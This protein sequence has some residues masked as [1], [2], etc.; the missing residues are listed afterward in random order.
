MKIKATKNTAYTIETEHGTIENLMVV[1]TWNGFIELS[2]HEGSIFVR[3][4]ETNNFMSDLFNKFPFSLD[5]K[6]E[7]V[8]YA[9]CASKNLQR[10]FY[11]AENTKD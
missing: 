9:V 11:P 3:K 10:I 7:E 8:F 1:S 5:P 2:N 4:E 6:T